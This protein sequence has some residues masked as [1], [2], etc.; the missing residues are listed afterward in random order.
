MIFSI[1]N[2]LKFIPEKMGMN[3]IKKYRDKKKF[4]DFINIKFFFFLYNKAELLLT[5]EN[6]S[7]FLYLQLNIK[8][9][10]TAKIFF[11]IFLYFG[12][13]KIHFKIL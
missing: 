1:Y 3:M 13:I 9:L 12:L 2:F 11:L 10:I 7:N 8:Y 6:K 4:L 5:I